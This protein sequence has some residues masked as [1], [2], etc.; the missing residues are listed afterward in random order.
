MP[1]PVKN[2]TLADTEPVA[3]Y[4]SIGVIV[5]VIAATLHFTVDPAAVTN[6]ILA[7]IAVVAPLVAAYKARAKVTPVA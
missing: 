2:R 6:A 5:S 4:V 1:T 3:L 7:V